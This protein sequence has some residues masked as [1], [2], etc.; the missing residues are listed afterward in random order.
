MERRNF[1]LAYLITWIII[2]LIDTIQECLK[3]SL[4]LYFQDTW[5]IW[6]ENPRYKKYL[7]FVMLVLTIV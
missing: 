2:I 1:K 7:E 4:H 6:L 5:T 3:M